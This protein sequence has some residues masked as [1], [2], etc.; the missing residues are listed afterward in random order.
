MLPLSAVCTRPPLIAL[1]C[2]DVF[3]SIA[4]QIA[5]CCIDVFA[6]VDKVHKIKS[7]TFI[8]HGTDDQVVPFANG[9]W[10]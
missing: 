1:C 3:T 8:M 5:L 2:I 10:P 4:P 7:P 9:A 6:S